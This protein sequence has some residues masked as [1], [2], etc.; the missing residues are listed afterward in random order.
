MKNKGLVIFT[1]L[2]VIVLGYFSYRLGNRSD[3]NI[4]FGGSKVK[5]PTTPVTLTYWRTLDSPDTLAP[6][7]DDF[8][9]LH[10][11][12]EVKLTVVPYGEYS[13]KLAAAAAAGQLPD[14]FTVHNDQVGAYKQYATPAPETVFTP[15]DYEKTFAPQAVRDLTSSGVPFALTYGISTLGL[16]YNEAL[17]KS[18]KIDPPKSWQDVLTASSKL[19]KKSGSTITQSG[20]ALGTANI[21]RAT[22]I[23]SVLMMQNGTLMTDT[24]PTKATFDQPDSSGY[25]GGVKA[26]QFYAS[27]AMPSKSDY[28]WSDSLGESVE[29][30][31]KEKTAM[32]INYPFRAAGVAAANPKLE[33]K[34]APLPQVD[35]K[36]PTN[37]GEYWAEMVSQTSGHSE[38]AWDFLRFASSRD[39]LNKFSI[40][41][42]RPAS[43]L[44]L[45][46]AQGGDDLLGP[47]A[48]QVPTSTNW[49]RGS[50]QNVDAIF[51][52]MNAAILGGYDA[53]ATVQ[54]AARRVSQE[55]TRSQK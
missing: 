14:L 45:A 4:S 41:S 54:S 21:N 29:A 20:I 53:T 16:F 36:K 18:A 52:D 55:I 30:F 38:I 48:R 34:T 9:K 32:I 7:I 50:Y 19:T 10:P 1:L 3:L 27:F 25:Y 46:K 22:D 6:I 37:L 5:Y 26:A 12:V 44:D 35:S 40:T 51:Y 39:E 23:E 17:L 11:N 8:K 31:A 2:A 33:F 28:S 13:S 43:R 49:Y 42:Q 24:P 47:F 15:K